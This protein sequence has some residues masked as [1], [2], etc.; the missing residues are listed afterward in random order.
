MTTMVVLELGGGSTLVTQPVIIKLRCRTSGI[1][2]RSGK[3]CIHLISP[4]QRKAGN[5]GCEDENGVR[6]SVPVLEVKGR[7]AEKQTN[8][9]T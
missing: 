2:C 9:V 4:L 5:V 8:C 1:H 7:R 6:K 3:E